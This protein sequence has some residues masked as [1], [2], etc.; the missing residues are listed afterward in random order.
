M[1]KTIKRILTLALV[2]ILVV[3][4]AAP[5]MALS[6]SPKDTTS[7]NPMLRDSTATVT[8]YIALD[9]AN[10]VVP[11]VTFSFSI[12]PENPT[13]SVNGWDTYEGVAGASV[14]SVSFTAGETVHK[15]DANNKVDKDPNK[16]YASKTTEIDFSGVNFTKPGA[17]LYKLVENAITGTTAGFTKDN[18]EYYVTVYVE[19]AQLKDGSYSNT[20]SIAAIVVTSNKDN[21]N[22][23]ANG[24]N[25]VGKVGGSDNKESGDSGITFCNEYSTRAL[26]LAKIVTGNQGDH[27]KK[28]KFT[29]NLAN[30]TYGGEDTEYTYSTKIG[31][32][33]RTGTITVGEDG[34]ADLEVELAHNDTFEIKGLPQGATYTITETDASASGYTTT[35]SGAT[36]NCSNVSTSDGKRVASG[37][38]LSASANVIFT[39]HKEGTVPTGILLTVAPFAVLM[40]VGAAGVTVILKRKHS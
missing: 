33:T 24:S 36:T 27:T 17:Y 8:K 20:L 32:Q 6:G 31:S 2:A 11:N 7:D 13:N 38:P 37:G 23:T 10:A 14:G 35:S 30:L 5:A 25:V 18:T 9:S 26:T 39:N 15:G 40:I 4:L 1:N 12:T 29:I 21:L 19:Y 34:T 28:F 16:Y 3:A 22:Y